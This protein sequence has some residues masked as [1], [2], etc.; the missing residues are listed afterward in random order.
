M[1]DFGNNRVEEFSSYGEY[2]GQFGSSGS[3]PGQLSGPAGITISGENL[4]VAEYNNNRVSEFTSAGTFIAKFGSAGSGE[5]QFSGPNNIAT[6][7]ETGDLYVADKNNNRMEEF[8]PNGTFLRAFGSKGSGNGQFEANG[9]QDV[10]V[11]GLGEIYITDTANNRIQE[12]ET[13]YSFGNPVPEPPSVGSN[14]VWTLEYYLSPYYGTP[15]PLGKEEVEKWGQKDDSTE[16]MAIYPPDKP[17]GWP[18]STE[19]RA[20]FDYMDEQG[21]TVN[22]VW[23]SRGVATTEY[24]EANEVVRT[25]TADNRAAA[26]K[27]GCKSVEK[28]ECKS[29]EVSEKLDTK[30]EYNPEDSEI[31][32]V[33]G[34]EHKVK[35]STGSE[36]EARAV[37]HDYYDEGAK[38]AEEKNKETYNLVTKSTTGALLSSGEEKDKRETLN[39]YSGQEDL[40]WKLRKPTSVTTEPGGLNLTTTTLYNETTGNVIETRSPRAS[41]SGVH[42]TP[43]YASQFGTTG[44]ETERLWQPMGGAL[45]S[46]GD[47]WVTSHWERLEELSA[48]GG[49]MKAVGSSGSGAGQMNNPMGVAINQSNNDVYVA[50]EKNERVDEFNEKGEFVRAFGFGV[51]NGKEEFEICTTT[52]GCQAGKSGFGAGQFNAPVGIAI[53]PAGDVWVTDYSNNRVEKFKENGEFI[54]AV[55]WGVN[56]E[57]KEKLET[58]TSECKAGLSGSGNGEFNGATRDV[59]SNGVLYV[60]DFNNQRV[61]ELNEKGEYLGQFGSKGTGNG[62]FTDPAG[63]SADAQGNIYVTEIGVHDRVQE[64]TPTGGFLTTFGNDGSGNEQMT[65]PMDVLVGS[66]GVLYVIDT[67]NDRVDKWES[68]PQAPAYT[69]QFGTTG[70]E[71]ER[72]WQPMG[73]ALDSRGDIWVTSHWERL[74]ELSASGGFMKAVGSSGSGAGQMN[75]PMGVAINQSNNDV[76]VADEKNERVDE[77]NEKGEFVRAFGFGVSNGKEEFEICTTTGGC[78][79]GKSGFGAGQFNAPVGIAI[80]PAGDVWVTDYSNNRVEKFKENGEFIEA[81]GWGVNHEGKEKLETCTSEC[82][83]GLS[84]S[85]NGEFNGATR[86]V[87]SNGVL[88]VTDFNN[89]RVQE[90]NEK[91]EYLGQFGSKGTGNGQFTDPAW[92]LGGCARQHLRHRNRRPRSCARVHADGRVPDDIRRRRVRPRTNDVADGCPDRLHGGSVRD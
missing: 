18:A 91:G 3:E 52:G 49:F 67:D 7:S 64:F 71:T 88:Y 11:G 15:E 74:E 82:K 28:H 2:E 48:S 26:M 56:H 16:G 73:G 31:V 66:T 4:Y 39:S 9:P 32:K 92:H 6:E 13:T 29:A 87:F 23:P 37:T 40:G 89:Q 65:W 85:G 33:V 38:E 12:W 25:L 36:V 77:F 83:A 34:P 78:Q 80:E 19:E 61:Q 69:S 35:L 57:G 58:C 68:V 24:N 79:A 44:S 59:F 30:T 20:T 47:I 51:S 70:S 72:V 22:T 46:R 53:E 76:Y 41:G 86:D 1:A 14:S 84:G 21:R 90:L 27:E 45:D 50:D 43:V 5:G 8:S 17:Q 81:V 63:I 60:T 42:P 54:E 62:Q 55:G 10:A 75:N